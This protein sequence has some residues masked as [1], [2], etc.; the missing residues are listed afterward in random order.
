MLVDAAQSFRTRPEDRLTELV[1]TV[2][3]G[4]PPFAAELLASLDLPV[5]DAFVIDAQLPVRGVGKPDLVIRAR[6][7]GAWLSQLW[8]EHKLNA[9]DQPEQVPRYLRHLREQ[10]ATGVPGELYYVS[11]RCPRP[12]RRTRWMPARRCRSR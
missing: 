5:G 12:G 6:K 8:F 9:R 7:G 2:A 3:A 1:A 4:C 11:R 10:A